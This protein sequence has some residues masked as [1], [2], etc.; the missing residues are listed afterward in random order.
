MWVVRKRIGAT[1]G[2]DAGQLRVLTSPIES[3]ASRMLPLM[4]F[5]HSRSLYGHVRE[6]LTPGCGAFQESE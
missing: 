1:G 2:R 4:D 5:N 6:A 3:C